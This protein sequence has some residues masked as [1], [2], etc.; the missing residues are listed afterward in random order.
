VLKSDLKAAYM[1]VLAGDD[2]YNFELANNPERAALSVKLVDRQVREE[3]PAKEVTPK[4]VRDARPVYDPEKLHTLLRLAA[5]GPVMRQ[6]ASDLYPGYECREVANVSDYGEVVATV[7]EIHR[8]PADDAVVLSGDVQ[9]KGAK[10]IRFNPAAVTVAVG[11]R[12]YPAAFIDCAGAVNPGQTI[13]FGLVAQGDLDG[14]RAH[15][16]ARNNF[17]VLLPDF[18]ASGGEDARKE[19]AR[20]K[21]SVKRKSRRHPQREP[22]NPQ[23]SPSKAAAEP[24]WNWPW[25]RGRRADDPQAKV[26]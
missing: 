20:P 25:Q 6:S 2:L 12:E 14:G 8:F 18:R 3:A 7:K 24:R 9:N 21:A 16:A 26:N 11:D 10:A 22:A 17:R 13:K 19:P 23:A 1:T 15:L 5:N 4:Q